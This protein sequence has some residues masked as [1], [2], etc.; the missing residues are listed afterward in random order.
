MNSNVD[1]YRKRKFDE[2]L[3]KNL[4][5]F[6]EAMDGT[7]ADREEWASSIIKR[8]YLS[9]PDDVSAARLRAEEK[10]LSVEL[11]V[12]RVNLYKSIK[13]DDSKKKHLLQ[14]ERNMFRDAYYDALKIMTDIAVMQD[15]LGTAV[16][17]LEKHNN[18]F[19]FAVDVAFG[20]YDPKRDETLIEREY[21]KTDEK[22]ALDQSNSTTISISPPPADDPPSSDPAAAPVAVPVETPAAPA[23]TPAAAPSSDPAETPAAVVETPADAVADSKAA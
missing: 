6:Q 20:Q 18:R 7:R 10:D 14:L 13:D 16:Y 19:G 9:E 22:D 12:D 15:K 2:Y 21:I 4:E 8:V 5:S 1:G 23:E 11:A 17:D 3:K